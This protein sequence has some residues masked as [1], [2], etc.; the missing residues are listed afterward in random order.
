MVPPAYTLQR[1][2]ACGFVT[3]I[4]RES[5]AVSRCEPQAADTPRTPTSRGDQY[6]T[7]GRTCRVSVCR[8]QDQPVREAETRKPSNRP[9]PHIRQ[10]PS[11]RKGGSQRPVLL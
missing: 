7:H 8:P 1:C 6:Q 10:S 5:Q 3:E 11:S 9:N 2:A 4:N